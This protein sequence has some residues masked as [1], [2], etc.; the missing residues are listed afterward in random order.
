MNEFRLG[1]IAVSSD[2][3]QP[4]Q[5]QVPEGLVHRDDIPMDVMQAF[6]AHIAEK[7][8]GFSVVCAGDIA[9]RLPPE[10]LEKLQQ[11]EEKKLKSL[12]HGDCLWCG[13]HMPNYPDDASDFPEGWSPAE[14]WGLMKDQ[15]DE[16]MGWECPDCDNL[17]EE[18][19]D[20]HADRQETQEEDPP[21][22]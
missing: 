8:P 10:L 1:D 12:V 18:E 6:E 21:E 15:N 2:S 14:G 5:P 19:V 16:P 4:E 3:D 7:F 22:A 11:F 13:A 20:V 17:V 9:D